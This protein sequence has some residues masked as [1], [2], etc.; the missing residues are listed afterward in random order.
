VEWDDAHDRIDAKPP[1]TREFDEAALEHQAQA[2]LLRQMRKGYVRVAASDQVAVGEPVLETGF[3]LRA[4]VF[5]FAPSGRTVVVAQFDCEMS[6]S[7]ICVE[8]ATGARTTLYGG[9]GARTVYAIS[10]DSRGNAL[11]FQADQTVMRLELATGSVSTIATHPSIA[12][13][14]NPGRFNDGRAHLR[15]DAARTR[16]LMCDGERIVVRSDAGE[17]VWQH[18]LAAADQQCNG[19]MLSRGGGLVVL[20]VAARERGTEVSRQVWDLRRG[21]MIATASGP[22]PVWIEIYRDEP[23]AALAGTDRVAPI[24]TDLAGN[25]RSLAKEVL[26]YTA[27]YDGAISPNGKTLAFALKWGAVVLDAETHVRLVDV[28]YP[29]V[30][31]VRFS[32][33]GALLAVAGTDGRFAVL[34]APS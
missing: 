7:L 20:E 3:Q 30:Q 23:I 32:D 1:K 18:D 15:R 13:A 11:W 29:S 14:G 34:R 12:T 4:D 19:A 10:F 8:L 2:E 25:E 28:R 33:D 21:A 26:P 9:T 27:A 31:A 22:P 16:W 5:D 17:V 6:Y 24:V